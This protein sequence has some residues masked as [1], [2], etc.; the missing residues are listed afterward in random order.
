LIATGQPAVVPSSRLNR[1]DP[2]ELVPAYSLVVA[3]WEALRLDLDAELERLCDPGMLR[4]YGTGHGRA[5]RMRNRLELDDEFTLGTSP[6]ARVLDHGCV[7][8]G[9]V[10]RV[11]ASHQAVG[12]AAP[13]EPRTWWSIACSGSTGWR[14]QGVLDHL[15]RGR[16]VEEVALPREALEPSEPRVH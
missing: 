10:R 9:A 1:V 6:T 14:I 15:P 7:A 2:L 16:V 12:P 4:T 11:G 5:A 8:F 13:H 3:F